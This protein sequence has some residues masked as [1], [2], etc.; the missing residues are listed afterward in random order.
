MPEPVELLVAAE[1]EGAR[2]DSW[3]AARCPQWS[4]S[5]LQS[6]IK[7]G[8]VAVNARTVRPSYA[9]CAGDRVRL[10]VPEPEALEVRPEAMPLDIVYEDA[11]LLILNKAAGMTVHPAPGH[12]SG[13]LV[14]ALLHH[15]T[16]LSGINGVL[17]PGIVHRLDKETS[18]LMAVA[19]S[20]AAHRGLA[21]QLE[22]RS[23]ERRYTALCWGRFLEGQG[24]VEA[25]V[26][27]HRT[28]R[29]RMAVVEGGRQ[30]RTHYRLLEE[31]AF[32]SLVELKLDTGRTHQIRVHM[33][34]LHRPV[35]GDPQYGGRG[36]AAG[37][38]PAY[39]PVAAAWLEL[40]PRQAL[41]AHRLCLVHPLSGETLA[42]ERPP[43][44]DMAAVI[45]A[46]RDGV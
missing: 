46:A 44:A 12:W 31:F 1:D 17:R 16:D 3:L 11:D 15:C 27:R 13:T 19:K 45:E 10:D 43:P 25:P 9:V 8:A 37:L 35:F 14:N 24:T 22:D 18:G 42:F 23:I 39:R 36:Q 26:G 40:L 34:H 4:R 2:L 5:R 6:L 29:Q 41:H 7:S 38:K 32:L 28:Q 20:D 30:A 21:A 33:Q